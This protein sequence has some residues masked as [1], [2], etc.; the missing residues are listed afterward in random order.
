VPIEMSELSIRTGA[1]QQRTRVGQDVKETRLIVGAYDTAHAPTPSA[2]S[3]SVDAVEL[4][5]VVPAPLRVGDVPGQAGV[6]GILV[7][8]AVC[9]PCPAR[10]A[11]HSTPASVWRT[12]VCVAT[13]DGI[14]RGW[15]PMDAGLG[16]AREAAAARILCIQRGVRGVGWRA[17][18]RLGVHTSRA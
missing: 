12:D 18:R 10:L 16:V 14:Q 9:L 4:H 3:Q 1:M 7:H 11:H 13:G 2:L 5:A 15:G 8:A 6:V 17:R